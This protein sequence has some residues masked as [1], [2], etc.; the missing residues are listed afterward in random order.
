MLVLRLGQLKIFK[1]PSC[2]IEIETLNGVA[3]QQYHIHPHN[4]QEYVKGPFR[5]VK[6]GG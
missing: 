3:Q 4:N 1:G 5:Q 6:V 2:E